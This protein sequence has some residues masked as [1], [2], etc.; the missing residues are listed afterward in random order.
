L[1]SINWWKR[2]SLSSLV[3]DFLCRSVYHVE[4]AAYD[5]LHLWRAIFVLVLARFGHEFERTEHVAMVGNGQRRLPVRH[6]FLVQRRYAG[7]AVKQ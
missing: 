2:L 1:A 3:K 4:F 5:G 6:G 7:S